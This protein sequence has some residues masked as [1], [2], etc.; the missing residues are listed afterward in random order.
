MDFYDLH[1]HSVFSE[2]KSSIEEIANIASR[3]GYK[4]MCFSEY[5]RGRGRIEKLKKM[6]KRT[7]NEVGIKIYLGFEARNSKELTKLVKLRREFDVL[8]VHGGDV[9]LNRIAVETPEVDILTHPELERNDS[10]LDQVS[11]K[12]AAKNK[13]AIEVNF[14]EI[15]INYKKSRS[16]I[17]SFI[18][19]N[20]MLAKKFHAPIILCSGA[21]THWELKDPYC[22][23]SMANQLG[24]ELKEAKDAISKIPKSIISQAKE[25]KNKK[26]IMPGVKVVE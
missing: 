26:W 17:L 16:K 23:I 11:V 25:R 10:G 8:L 24:L 19:R 22:L 1:V 13:V 18:R 2:G 14:R 20:I 3:L 12:F 9:D 7:E 21:V 15:L 4:G 5:F 6:I